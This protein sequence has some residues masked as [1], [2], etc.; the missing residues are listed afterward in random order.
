MR[1]AAGTIVFIVG[2][3]GFGLEAASFPAFTEHVIN[4]EAEVVYAVDA[5]DINGDKKLD[6]IGVSA[7]YV[8]W[9]EN[10]TWTQH[11]IADQLRNDNVCAAPYDIDG[12]G[13]PEIAVG[14]D[15]QF[16]NTKGGGA[17]YLLKHNGDPTKEWD[18]TTI[19]ESIPT[20][21]RIRWADVDG[22]GKKELVVA[23]LKGVNSHPPSFDDKPIRLRVLYPPA[24]LSA[25]EWREEIVDESLHVCHNVWPWRRVGQNR[26]DLLAASFEGVSHFV[27][28]NDG[29]WTK[30][31]LAPG[32]YEPA[33]RAGSGEI[34]VTSVE[35]YMLAAI[36]PW[37]AN[38]V[39]V[40]VYES[41]AWRREVLDDS[42]AGGHLVY[43]GDFDGDGDEDVVAGHRD[44][45]SVSQT[46]GLYAY[47]Q[48]REDGKTRW[49]KH[50]IDAGGMAT[51]DGVVADING[52]G[53]P[54]IVAGGRSTHNIKYYENL[55]AK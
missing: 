48:T 15:W 22:D 51:E 20:L 53:R 9:Y 3:L 31:A 24:D 27:R 29:R 38:H 42:F 37:H 32:N 17:L 19:R 23:P 26:D 36:E 39:V 49:T 34:K 21:H 41:G 52:D 33:P 28:G 47:E 6:I 50:T 13:V 12:D 7:T 30:N 43:W 44:A 11:R 45:S 4:P 40:Y 46:V 25:G 14:A 8:A 54:D 2:C 16:N 35:P 18:V 1:A 55:G 5:A 10:S